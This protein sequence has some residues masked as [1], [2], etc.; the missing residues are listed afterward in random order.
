MK[1]LQFMI[2]RTYISSPVSSACHLYA[3]ADGSTK[4]Y[5]YGAVVYVCQNQEVSLVMSKCHVALIK[6]VTMELMAAVMATRLVQFVNSVIHLLPDDSYSQIHMWTDSQIVLH[7]IYKSRNQS[8]PFISHH[9]T[10]IVGAFP[11]NS[12][13]FTPS[14]DNPVDL[15]TRGISAQQLFSSEVWFHGPPWLL[16]RQDWPQLML[17]YNWQKKMIL[18]V[19]T[20]SQLIRTVMEIQQVFTILS[21]S[22]IIVLLVSL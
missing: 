22:H 10:E 8:K 1:L 21:T 15:L 13:S 3:F 6:A 14:E 11:A 5:V 18:N 4:V 2:P 12:W 7:W 19:R 9:V 20:K 17:Y 16:S